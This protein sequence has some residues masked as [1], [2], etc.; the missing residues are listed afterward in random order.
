VTDDM[1]TEQL[2]KL[3][4]QRAAWAP[5]EDRP[6][7]GDQ[8][9]VLLSTGDDGAELPEG[10][11]YR[12]ELGGGQAIAAIEELIMETHPG[13]TL[14]R[15]VKWPDD[16]PDETQRGVTKRV[17]VELREVKRKS[18]PDLDDALAREVGDFDS[19]DALT[20]AVRTD[21][22][23]HVQRE[24]EA[25]VRQQLVEQIIEANAFDV[26]PS[27]VDRL[28]KAY[29]D[30]YQVPEAEQEQF[31]AEFRPMAERQVRRDMVIDAVAEREQL[32]ATEA[33][34]DDRV[35]EIAAQR[36]ANPSQIYASLQ[37]AGRLPEIERSITE[38]KVFKYLLEQNAAG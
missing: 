4:E 12:L 35:A 21:L 37:K 10:K 23:Q 16:F 19:L 6:M 27:W 32:T 5:V 3:R 8:V 22:E 17:R 24:A 11:E 7:P 28:G 18:L 34:V 14:E 26:P 38:E 9:T 1:V 33:D 36:S 31:I 30:A 20:A 13:D 29:A 25:A 2:D 15:P